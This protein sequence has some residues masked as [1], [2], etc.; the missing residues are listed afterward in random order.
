MSQFNKLQSLKR[1][2][3][4][5]RNGVVADSLR[6]GGAPYRIIFGVNL[7]QLQEI[8]SGVG[9]DTELA[10]QLWRNSTTRESMLIAP[11]L[12]S[13]ADVGRHDAER[14]AA[15]ALTP[16][17]ADVLCH[18]LLRHLPYAFEMALALMDSANPMQ[19]YCALRILWHYIPAQNAILEPIARTELD[20]REALTARVARQTLDEINFWNEE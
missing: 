18:K 3:F 5:M 1:R 20:R 10:A 7:P 9:P 4:A 15:E 14:M 17:V 6:R 8:A 13:P 16:E 19:R 2:L 12:F 11:M